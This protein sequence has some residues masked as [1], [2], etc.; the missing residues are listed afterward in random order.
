[1]DYDQYGNWILFLFFSSLLNEDIPV[2]YTPPNI[3]E[4]VTPELILEENLYL[5]LNYRSVSERERERESL[6][7]LG[8]EKSIPCINFAH[9]FLL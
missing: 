2:K 3:K 1:M 4:A 9:F 7:F 6:I 8:N 5:W